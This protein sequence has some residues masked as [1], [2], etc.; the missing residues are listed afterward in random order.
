MRLVDKVKTLLQKLEEENWI[1]KVKTKWHPPEGLFTKDPETIAKTIAKA[2]KDLKQAVARVNFFYNRYGCSGE[3]RNDPICKKREKVLK[4]LHKYFKKE[5]EED[6][7]NKVII[8]YD[9]KSYDIT[10]YSGH[11]I[12]F[13]DRKAFLQFLE[14]N[15]VVSEDGKKG[16]DLVREVE[17]NGYVGAII[18]NVSQ[19][20]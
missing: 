17:R 10:F 6:L 14:E 8:S 13:K 15:D 3:R 7:R 18:N 20:F 4:L 19:I 11:V 9:G 1:D 16:E 5:S 2:S 12:S